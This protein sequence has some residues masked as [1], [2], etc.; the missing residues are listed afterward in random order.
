MIQT[1]FPVK[2]I[3][4]QGIQDAQF[5]LKK[6]PTQVSLTEADLITISP[7]GGYIVLDFGKELCGG[8][9]ISTCWVRN[10]TRFVYLH[11]RFGE[12]LGEVYAKIGEKNAKNDH[13]PRDFDFPV[14]MLSTVHA[15]ET[16]FRFVRIDFPAGQE[17]TL[18]TIVAKNRILRRPAIYQY[19]GPD[20]RICA[21][22]QAAKRTVDLCSSSG[23]IWDGVK[24]DRLVWA[25][26]LYPEI[27]SLTTLYGKLDV[28]ENSL[29][30]ESSKP[31]KPH[32]QWLC[33]YYTYNMWWV[34]CLSAYY[35]RV[36]DQ[37]RDFVLQ[38]LPFLLQQFDLF[39]GLI[40]ENG[41]IC[42]LPE[43][44][45]GF[46]DWP[47]TDKAHDQDVGSRCIT[48]FA[49]QQ[50]AQ[51]LDALGMDSEKPRALCARLMRGDFQ[52][53]EMKAVIAL[54][55]LAFGTL[56]DR[57]Y[58][59]LIDGGAKGFSTFMSYFL[60]N[61]I[62]SRDEGLAIELMKTYFGAMLD[63]GSTTF[64][65]DFDMD[66]VENS[67]SIDR[68]PKDGER[69]IHGDFGNYCYVG[70]RHSLC[71]AWASGVITFIQEHC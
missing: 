10:P 51:L 15:G 11:V 54:K 3:A 65:E 27:L 5:L 38:E 8:I 23:Y 62:A 64:W 17:I 37:V 52:V 53:E 18:K 48:L 9:D 26:D 36:G 19:N 45:A 22:F 12:S 71:H 32:G 21:I 70:Y 69:D 29:H 68:L 61:A 4:S 24:R 56:S 55:Y 1:V 66:W 42:N 41:S 33:G 28:I 43:D 35:L 44:M 7:E 58:E 25:G 60:L 2:I 6:R 47:C 46:V 30:Y 16:G 14:S 34:A 67:S 49:M 31:C 13:A 20:A 57:E 40:D 59:M 63:K 39:D 50:A